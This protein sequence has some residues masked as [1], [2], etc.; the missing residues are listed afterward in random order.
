ISIL[1]RQYL[2]WSDSWN[3]GVRPR[4]RPPPDEL[5]P[6]RQG[7]RNPDPRNASWRRRLPRAVRRGVGRAWERGSR[8]LPAAR[9]GKRS[10]SFDEALPEPQV[11]H[12]GF[13]PDGGARAFEATV[14]AEIDNFMMGGRRYPTKESG[15][16][17]GGGFEPPT[18]GF[19]IRCSTN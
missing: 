7:S 9:K 18:R 3:P 1:G 17:P 19:S 13:P 10:S 16:V 8:H 2:L 15:M 14:A 5:S 6:A 12:G 4:A 11:R